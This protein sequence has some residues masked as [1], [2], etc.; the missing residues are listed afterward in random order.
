M[1]RNENE[2]THSSTSLDSSSSDSSDDIEEEANLVPNES[3]ESNDSISTRRNESLS[4]DSDVELENLTEYHFHV[5]KR[6][7]IES[8]ESLS[9]ADAPNSNVSQQG[10]CSIPTSNVESMSHSN[11]GPIRQNL[12]IESNALSA[13]E[14]NHSMSRSF[15]C[16]ENAMEES[17]F[18]KGLESRIEAHLES[19]FNHSQAGANPSPV[20]TNCSLDD[21]SLLLRIENQQEI[22]A[23]SLHPAND[24][25]SCDLSEEDNE[26]SKGFSTSYLSNATLD[27]SGEEQFV[28]LRGLSTPVKETSC[29]TLHMPNISPIAQSEKRCMSLTSNCSSPSCD[30]PE[31]SSQCSVSQELQSTHQS[32]LSQQGLPNNELKKSKLKKALE[33]AQFYN[34]VKLYDGHSDSVTEAILKVIDLLIKNKESK[35]SFKRILK[36]ICDLLPQNH[37]LPTSSKFMLNFIQDFA[38]VDVKAS[39]HFY[40]RD[41]LMYYKSKPD[42]CGVCGKVTVLGEFFSFDLECI[43]RFFFEGRNLA[44]IMD[45]QPPYSNNAPLEIRDVQDGSVYRSANVNRKKYDINFKVATDGVRVRKGSKKEGWLLMITPVE[46]PPHLSESFTTVVA[47]W[48]DEVKPRGNT[49]LKPFCEQVASLKESGV[50]WTH[51][52]TQVDHRSDVKVTLVIADAPARAMCQNLML[53]NSKNGCNICEISTRKSGRIPGKRRIRIYRYVHDPQLRTN[54]R[55][56]AQAIE[57]TET[58]R[59]CKGVKGPSVLSLIPSLDISVCVIPEYMHCVLLGVTKQLLTLW[60]EKQGAWCIKTYVEHLSVLLS[61]I[62]HPDFIHRGKR[63]VNYYKKWKAADFYYLLLFE[64]LPVLSGILPDMYYQHFMLLVISIFNLLQRGISEDDIVEADYLLKLFV[65]QFTDLYS[66]RE[67]TYNVHN[68]LHLSLCVRRFGPLSCTSSFPFESLN[69]IISKASHATNYVAKEIVNNMKI[70]QGAVVLKSIAENQ[71]NDIL[72]GNIFQTKVLGRAKEVELSLNDINCLTEIA[73]VSNFKYFSKAQI[74]RDQL[75]SEIHKPLTTANYYVMWGEKG[76]E[77]YGSVKFFVLYDEEVFLYIRKLKIDHLSV[78]YHTQTLKCVK[79]IIPISVSNDFLF[80]RA[81]TLSPITKVGR[82]MNF[83][84]KRPNLMRQIM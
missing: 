15:L 42:S 9:C 64:S 48:Y 51:P 6:K 44:S 47:V 49:F 79:H 78:L 37:S 57:A 54:E 72:Q 66:D 39:S 17:F 35:S 10:E 82:V 4:S 38:P 13:G 26:Q 73:D 43:I 3:S 1:L 59:P 80:C 55:M 41:C 83:I 50:K 20:K 76:H 31:D 69:G 16:E 11:L 29:A 74:G 45:A 71:T 77:N 27:K 34:S 28:G 33:L 67:M 36:T 30:V 75:T 40:C 24:S 22:V 60:I 84:I 81:A 61:G 18:H 14:L 8:Q 7:R 5:L 46:V 2:S 65:N 70:Y 58:G 53:F 21:N 56:Q 62:K 12:L 52:E 19:A 25:V 63:S 68:L 23:K 32:D